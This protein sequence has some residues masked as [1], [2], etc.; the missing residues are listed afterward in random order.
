[1]EHKTAI[2]EIEINK[3]SDLN[4]TTPYTPSVEEKKKLQLAKDKFKLSGDTMF[5]T[6]QGEGKSIGI[7]CVFIRLHLCNL[8]CVWCDTWYTWHQGCKEFWTESSDMSYEELYERLKAYPCKRLVFTGGEPLLQQDRIAAFLQKYPEFTVEVETNGT[9]MPNEYLLKNA[10][11]NCSPKLA[12]SGNPLSLRFKPEVL[13]AINSANCLFKFVAKDKEDLDEV[14]RDF[15]DSGIL[16]IENVSIMP[17]GVNLEEN[18]KAL[19]AIV[20]I[21]KEY[22]FRVIPRLQNVIWGAKRRV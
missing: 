17:E 12:N 19:I 13:K 1:M 20:D 8:Q 16:S 22:G 7:P 10:Q 3:A 5:F 21:C 2:A 15:V 6:V 11:F 14:K 4:N 18:R 9:I